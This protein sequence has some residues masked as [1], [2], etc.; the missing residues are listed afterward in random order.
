MAKKLRTV[1]SLFDGMSC[2]QIA[3]KELGIEFDTYYAS[4]IDKNAITNTQLNFPNTI[5]LGDIEKWREWDID[6]S[7]VDLI[8]A[9]SPCQGFST[10]GKLK[11]FND[12]R[13]KL[14]WVFSAILHHVEE[15][16][17]NVYFLLENVVLRY[18]WKGTISYDL[19]V[20]PLQINSSTLTAQE[21]R[22]LYWTNIASVFNKNTR[23]FKTTIPQ[24]QNKGLILRDVLD[25]DASNYYYYELFN[26][27]P[28]QERENVRYYETKFAHSGIIPTPLAKATC[29]VCDHGHTGSSL[30]DGVGVRRFTIKEKRRLQGIPDWYHF[31]DGISYSAASNLLGNGWTVDVIKHILSYL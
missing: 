15:I 24:P 9:G 1:L 5:Q 7:K 22:R 31:V 17:E 29:L 28:Y 18:D 23:L 21:R 25:D 13:S 27:L 16:N 19:G 11:A 2:G 26:N 8:L 30:F 3:L 12:L 20:E 10:A 6:W 4:E 14:F